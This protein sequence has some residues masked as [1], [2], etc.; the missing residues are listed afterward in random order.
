MLESVRRQHYDVVLMDCQ[1][2][3]LD[4]Y[5]ATRQLRREEAAGELG[6]RRPVYI[7]ALTANAMAG[8][9]ERCLAVGATDYMSK[10][11]SLKALAALIVRLLPLTEDSI[12]AALNND[13]NVTAHRGATEQH[14]LV[15][16]TD[17]TKGPLFSAGLLF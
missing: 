7:V 14:R 13:R 5:E 10:P 12:T 16:S 15:F 11:V 8:D 9:R 2:P 17:K 1:M 6:N 3:E 4:G